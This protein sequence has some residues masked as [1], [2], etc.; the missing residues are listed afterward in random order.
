MYNA[1]FAFAFSNGSQ[2]KADDEG[3]FHPLAPARPRPAASRREWASFP[4]TRS[5]S[6]PLRSPRWKEPE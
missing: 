3:T 2:H 1:G 5:P 6:L 4:E